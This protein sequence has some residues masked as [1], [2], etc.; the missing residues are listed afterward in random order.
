MVFTRKHSEF[1]FLNEN[2][3]NG[4]WV[5]R[6]QLCLL[7]FGQKGMFDFY[8]LIAAVNTTE[9]A[10]HTSVC[11]FFVDYMCSSY[12]FLNRHKYSARYV[13]SPLTF[14]STTFLYSSSSSSVT[15]SNGFLAY[16]D[17]YTIALC[18]CPRWMIPLE[19]A[20]IS[21]T[22]SPVWVTVASCILRASSHVTPSRMCDCGPAEILSALL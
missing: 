10:P 12:I 6:T 1:Y 9:T 17:L 22:W 11:L 14:F 5:R 19:A 18:W 8:N 7:E 20:P 4:D 16:G 21:T 2:K 13:H 15:E 3:Q